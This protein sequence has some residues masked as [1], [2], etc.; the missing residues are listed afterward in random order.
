MKVIDPGHTYEVEVYDGIGGSELITFMKRQGPGFPGNTSA[1]PGT[2]CQE[3]LRV[4]ID[5]LKY[6][7]GQIPCDD[8][9]RAITDLRRCLLEF[10]RRAA[11]RHGSDDLYPVHLWDVD[12]VPVELADTCRVCGHLIIAG[13]HEDCLDDWQQE[14]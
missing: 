8:N 10:E 3:V 5:R 6:L 7:D 13:H 11:I 14:G 12:E 1:Y 2:N 4:L 9:K